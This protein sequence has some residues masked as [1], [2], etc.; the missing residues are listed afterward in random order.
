MRMHLT[1]D[2]RRTAGGN[3][4]IIRGMHILLVSPYELGRQPFSLA[5][6]AAL[7][8]ARGHSVALADLTL[9]SMPWETL[10]RFDLIGVTLGMHT[11]TRIAISLLPRIRTAAPRSRLVC[12][13]LYG[14][15]NAETLKSHGVDHVL[16][17]EFETELLGLLTHPQGIKSGSQRV[18]FVTPDRAGLPA[19]SR[20]A[21]LMLPDGGRKT[22]GFVET[23][24]GCK[25]LCRHCPIVPVYQ[26]RFRAIPQDVVIADAAQQIALG[27][28]HL[29]FGDP[30]FLNGPTHALRILKAV[31]KNWPTVTFDATVKISHVLGHEDLMPRLAEYGCLFLTSAAESFDDTV[32]GLLDKG[33]TAQDIACAVRITRAS[34]IALTPTFVPFTPWTTL[35]T[36]LE[37]L[38]RVRDLALIN[39]VT[40]IQL[41]IRLLVPAGSYL[42]QIPG[43]RERLGE[44]SGEVLGYPWAHVDPR[45]DRLQEEAQH[46]VEKGEAEERGRL[47]I[48]S[49]LWSLAHKALGQSPPALKPDEAGPESPHLSEPWYCCAEPTAA[50]LA[51]CAVGS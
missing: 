36:Y 14:P 11:A 8:R 16:G 51:D 48:F 38:T 19:L 1:C 50:Q 34:G 42:L 15:P 23:S 29:S 20:Y 3:C 28:T 47:E 31:R 21:H 25:Y 30:D 17:P 12:Y 43:F 35:E 13:G 32:L 46:C 49:G 41:V 39:S 18:R 37:L 27:A 10:A 33:H 26:G 24:R 7:L 45:V 9:G 40:P 5:H 22:V 44:F 6:P 4:R 2:P